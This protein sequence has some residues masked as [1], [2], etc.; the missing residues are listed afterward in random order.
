MYSKATEANRLNC[1]PTCGSSQ[2]YRY[3]ASINMAQSLAELKEENAV[4]EVK[5]EAAP[6][7]AEEE[8]EIEAVDA[9]SE[10]VKEVAESPDDEPGEA[11]TEDWMRT[12]EDVDKK[13]TDQDIAAAKNKFKAKLERKHDEEMQD[14]RA[15]NARLKS[16]PQSV[17]AQPKP[18]RDQFYDAVDPDE[19]YLDAVLDWKQDQSS[20]KGAVQANQAEAVR[21]QDAHQQEV[22][23]SV[24]QHY[25]RAVSLATESGISSELYQSAD[26]N[27]RSA[28]EAVLPKQ[29]DAVTDLLIANLGEGSEKVFYNLGVNETNR[30]KLSELLRT[31]PGGL[32]AAMYLGSLK[33]EL[34]APSKRTTNTRK[35]AANASGDT[36]P[37]GDD[38]SFKQKYD[39]ANKSGD[40]QSAF[41]ARMNAKQAGVNVTTW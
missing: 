6:Q 14:L 20:A 16:G 18:T 29:G 38:K 11:E 5:T 36:A 10:E 40:T 19:A 13:F 33:A 15:E 24:D 37:T 39:K 2:G 3:Q 4:E 9:G 31:D 25:E 1:N 17:E 7:V 8:A 23:T 34:T 35:P 28:I 22:N 12:D 41:T 21:R 32:K 27:V 26:M 30:N